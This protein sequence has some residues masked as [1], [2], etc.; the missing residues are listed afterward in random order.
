VSAARRW[1]T[2]RTRARYSKRWPLDAGRLRYY[3]VLAAA[4][5]LA[6]ALED[7]PDEPGGEPKGFTSPE[8]I[9]ALTRF[10]ARAIA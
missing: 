10:I 4:R 8:Y 1:W 7:Q 3:E 2:R 6:G 5:R 9:A